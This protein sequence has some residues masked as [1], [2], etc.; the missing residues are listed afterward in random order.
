MPQGYQAKPYQADPA[1]AGNQAALVRCIGGTDTSKDKTGEAHSPD[2]VFQNNQISSQAESF[3][4]KK[5]LDADVALISSPN[6]SACYDKLLTAELASTLPAGSSVKKVTIKIT[7]HPAGQP[8]NV[9]GTGAGTIVVQSNGQTITL[10]VGVAFITGTL[11]ESEVDF[12]EVGTPIP[13]AVQ[14]ALVKKVAAR[15]AAAG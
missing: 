2:Y 10:D 15:T 7:A 3:R 9:V 4:T 5:D 14:S 11:I 13:A 8:S 12:L 1:D 6:T